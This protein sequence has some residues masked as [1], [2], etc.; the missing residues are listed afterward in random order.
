MNKLMMKK[1]DN[2]LICVT[3]PT[4]NGGKKFNNNLIFGFHNRI[5]VIYNNKKKTF[6]KREIEK[7]HEKLI[8]ANIVWTMKYAATAQ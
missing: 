5:H 4:D 2:Y 7:R 8:I 6:L 3:F 1:L